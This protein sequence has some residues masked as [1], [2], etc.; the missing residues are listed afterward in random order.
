MVFLNEWTVRVNDDQ[1]APLPNISIDQEWASY[2][3]DV[4][5]YSSLRTDSKGM[6]R[7][8]EVSERRT[9]G[10]WVARTIPVLLNVHGSWGDSTGSVRVFD[11]AVEGTP[12]AGAGSDSCGNP[13][14]TERPQESVFQVYLAERSESSTRQLLQVNGV[15][16]E[17]FSED[18]N[19][20]NPGG[21][22]ATRDLNGSYRWGPSTIDEF[23]PGRF[24]VSSIDGHRIQAEA[25]SL[26]EAAL[27][28]G[29][30]GEKFLE[31][32][33]RAEML[34]IYSVTKTDEGGAIE[35]RLPPGGHGL[36]YVPRQ[37]ESATHVY[38]LSLGPTGSKTTNF[39]EMKQLSERWF[40]FLDFVPG[41]RAR[42]P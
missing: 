7:F 29:E 26:Q 32:L 35:I 42:K 20:E 22:L 24:T 4:R 33:R 18:W 2:T 40:Y 17:Q 12:G 19:R 41:W 16:M 37:T 28:M 25:K 6:A 39:G 8:P 3:F 30:S 31:W 15:A 13:E 27:G 5:G 36:Y 9:V 11:D 21:H 23:T 10:E 1:S 38:L 14:C 34:G